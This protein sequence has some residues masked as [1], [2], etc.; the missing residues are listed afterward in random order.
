LEIG[1]H[2]FGTKEVGEKFR[3]EKK[4][5]GQVEKKHEALDLV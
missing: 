1:G 2:A 4:G 3:G 5:M